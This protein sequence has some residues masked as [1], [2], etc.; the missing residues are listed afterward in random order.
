MVKT[1]GK[2]QQGPR[3]VIPKGDAFMPAV[4]HEQLKKAYEKERPGKPQIILWA[5][6]LRKEGMGLRKITRTIG[7]EYSTVRGWLLRMM[8]ADLSRRYDE[9]SGRKK[10][11]TDADL[12][13]TVGGW[14]DN[15]PECY[16]F[17]S[18]TWQLDM[19]AAMLHREYGISYHTRKLQR[20]MKRWGFSYTKARPVP[21]KSASPEEQREFMNETNEEV[22]SLRDEGFAIFFEDEAG[23]QRWNSGGYGWR[24]TG[25]HDTV[26]TTF[27]KQSAKLFGVLGEDGYH[28]LP[29]AKLNSYTFVGFLKYLWKKYKKFV[30]VLDRASY[31]KS[32]VVNRFLASTNGDIKLVF[33]PPY[34]PQLNAIEIQWRVLKRLLAGRYFE[35]IEEIRNAI[36]HI[37]NNEM[38]S[39][40]VMDYITNLY[41]PK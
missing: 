18:G 39:V 26:K 41:R 32:G 20:M 3:E 37:V 17:V 28:I 9:K 30:L 10:Q 13:N 36:R 35:T 40:K 15:L 16:G 8:D 14:L 2:K 23:V 31:H 12:A 5:C 1:T 7:Q 25:A 11:K 38:K 22:V 33:L 29:V 27:S 21:A 19:V 4:T 24:R 34:T 6:L